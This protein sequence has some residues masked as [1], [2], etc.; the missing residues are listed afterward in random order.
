MAKKNM[1]LCYYRASFLQLFL[2][3]A[4]VV[5]EAEE[6]EGVAEEGA[7]DSLCVSSYLRLMSVLF[8]RHILPSLLTSFIVTPWSCQMSL[9]GC[10]T[11][12]NEGLC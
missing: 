8:P 7:A 11:V 9:A 4:E 1:S 6:E 2:D 5:E 10:A 3:G 12:E